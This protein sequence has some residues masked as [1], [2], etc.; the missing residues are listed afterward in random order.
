VTN[1]GT[2]VIN[3]QDPNSEIFAEDNSW[4]WLFKASGAYLLPF[5]VLTSANLEHRSGTAWARTATFSNG[6]RVGNQTLRVEPIGSRRLPAIN[7]L[8][9]RVE[10]RFAL[11][12]GQSVSARL[13]IFNALNINT[14]LSL[15]Q[16][17]AANFGQAVTII[18]PRIL[19]FSA[20]YT[21]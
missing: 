3:S 10:K 13:N 6:A 19:E 9:L 8:D 17:S 1:V 7:L 2:L 18:A 11:P 20:Q 12:R 16:N 14:V 21:F 5:N 15:R 4:E